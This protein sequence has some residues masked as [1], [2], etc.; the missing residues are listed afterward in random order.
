M[1]QYF[2]FYIKLVFLVVVIQLISFSAKAQNLWNINNCIEYALK[3]NID[4]NVAYNKTDEQQVNL[5][6]SKIQLLPD[7][8]LG[9]GAS[10]NFG[11]NIDANNNNVTY[12]K[13]F[14]NNYWLNSSIDLF[15]GLIKYNTIKFNK[16]LLSASK[17]KAKYL[18]NKLIFNVLTSYYTVLYSKGL[19]NVAKSQV[20]LSEKQYKRMQK[21]VDVGRESP[22]T[23][24]ELKSQWASDKLS[25]TLAE[26]NVSKT[27]L[28]LKQLLRLDE[29]QNFVID[30]VPISMYLFNE[31]LSV[32]SLYNLAVTV[33]PEIKQQEY[34][35]RAS[36]K[37]L[38]VAKGNISPRI[39]LSAG[40]STGYYNG[41]S[42]QYSSQLRNNQN[43]V[44]N[45]GIVI[46]IF[47]RGSVYSK[48]ERKKIAVNNQIFYLQKE[49][50]KLYTDIWKAVND[51][52]SAKKEYKSAQELYEFSE[53]SLKNVTVKMEK[54]LANTTDFE[55][56]KQHFISAKASLLKAKLIFIMRKQM[57]EFYS[58]GSWKHLLE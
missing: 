6:E 2:S 8:N 30:T 33:L 42:L 19:E 44:I 3:H 15:S 17:E 53:L 46:P 25:L 52:Q 50:D 28:D 34:L 41:D 18:K 4:L 23:V 20:A 7:L 13:T 40:Y 38:A 56:S 9:S 55:A 16:Y 29:K 27:I 5:S 37:D 32:D 24:Q 1:T 45:M 11:R 57:L 54:G 12:D 51:V 21:F 31:V 39:Y 48:I 26:N 35:Y 22:L 43:Q 49:Q 58:T 36:E 47:N 10:L 14:S